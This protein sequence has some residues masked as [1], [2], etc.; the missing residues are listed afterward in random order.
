MKPRSVILLSGGI[1]SSTTLAVAKERGFDLYAL[2]VNYGQRHRIELEAAR[3]VANAI[4]VLKHQVINLDLT[5][6]GGSALTADV[7]VP[8]GVHRGDSSIP[9]TYVP[10][11]NTIM[12]SLALGWAEVLGARTI[13]IGA[14]AI[15]YSGYPDCRPEFISS[16][17]IL[18][19]LAT[20]AGDEGRPF[21][22]EAPLISMTK[23]E[24]ITLGTRLGV[25]YSLT[26]SCYDPLSDGRACRECDSCRIRRKG[27]LEA[28]IADPLPTWGIGVGRAVRK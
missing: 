14:N 20:R 1:D 2:T 16:F 12:L 8:K 21:Q 4:G 9:A 24:I 25:D 19:N 28:G 22:I 13:F 26:H 6:F 3:R 27:F 7:D 18:A 15:D 5:L 23:A 10:A 11:R 17:E